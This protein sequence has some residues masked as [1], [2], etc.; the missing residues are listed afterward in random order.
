MA[1]PKGENHYA[2]AGSKVSYKP[3]HEWVRKNYLKTDTCEKCGKRS[4]LESANVSGEYKRDR[5]DWLFLCKSCHS[6]MDG[7]FDHRNN[8]G[9]FVQF[10]KHNPYIPLPN[11]YLQKKAVSKR[12][13]LL[14]SL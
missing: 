3:L 10:K 14:T 11:S 5:S 13:K 6:K 1:S 4:N 9:Q 8:K 2:W 12:L 7:I